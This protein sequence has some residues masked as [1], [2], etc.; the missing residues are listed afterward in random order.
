MKHKSY[1][2]KDIESMLE[3]LPSVKDKQTKADLYHKVRPK[4]DGKRKKH[5]TRWLVPGA[6]SIAVVFV[7]LLIIPAYLD[8][9]NNQFNDTAGETSTY[10]TEGF[11]SGS[12][13]SQGGS[14]TESEAGNGLEGERPEEQISD[15][16][17]SD[18]IL[19]NK[20]EDELKR[21]TAPTLSEGMR[22]AVYMDPNA[23][24]Y[25]PVTWI[26]KQEKSSAPIL[27][28]LQPEKYGLIP[29]PTPYRVN[30]KEGEAT[31]IF[32]NDFSVNGSSNAISIVQSL[33]WRMEFSQ[34]DS[35]KVQTENGDAVS[36]GN[37]GDVDQLPAIQQG[38]YY[39]Q[40]YENKGYNYLVP[41]SINGDSSIESAL[42]L[43][44]IDRNSTISA[45][46][47]HVNFESVKQDVERLL[48]QIN[49]GEWS[50]SQQRL[51]AIESVLMTARQF[52]YEEV[53]F[54]GMEMETDTNS[55]YDFSTPIQV[56]EIV[57]PIAP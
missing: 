2:D 9:A 34:I 21:L 7:L 33:R 45:I 14:P 8:D 49:H 24:I 36:L 11:D 20:P 28:D 42:Q 51:T 6:A 32:P 38:R 56:P 27:E 48:I 15:N 46:P 35:I 43:M 39:Y 12:D 10:S 37:Y 5:Y 44:K 57:N 52:G 50:N 25:I 17:Q 40:L 3:K 54:T 18:I 1:D 23:Q 31:V 22:P 47:A 26:S 30:K 29:V 41:V 19:D 16:E 55:V 53:L 4:L 13:S